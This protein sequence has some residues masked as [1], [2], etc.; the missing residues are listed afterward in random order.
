MSKHFP[1]LNLMLVPNS[2]EDGYCTYFIVSAGEEVGKIT[3]SPVEGFSKICFVDWI[4]VFDDINRNKGICSHVLKY[5][6]PSLGYEQ[7]ILPPMDEYSKSLFE[8]F[9]TPYTEYSLGAIQLE[10]NM[11]E[12]DRG[13]GLY[14]LNA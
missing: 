7:I 13:F 1:R 2:M 11:T 8:Q 5:I 12:F 10:E 6:L 3:Y 14:I 4:E 9:A